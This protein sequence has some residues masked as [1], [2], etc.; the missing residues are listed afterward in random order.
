MELTRRA[1]I[2]PG[3]SIKPPAKLPDFWE[4]FVYLCGAVLVFFWLSWQVFTNALGSPQAVRWS[5]PTSM[6]LKKVSELPTTQSPPITFPNI[7]CNQVSYRLNGESNMRSGCYSDSAYGMFDPDSQLMIFNGSDEALPILPYMAYQ[8]LVPWPGAEFLSLD[9]VNTGGSTLGLYTNPLQA[10]NDKR[11]L[12]FQ[13]TGKQLNRPPQMF[14]TDKTGQKLIINAQTLAFSENGAWM[15]AES[16]SRSIFRMNLASLDFKPFTPSFLSPSGQVNVPSHIAVEDSGQFVALFNSPAKTFRVYDLSSCPIKSTN[17]EPE[18]CPYHDY[19][20]FIKSQVPKVSTIKNL[21][22]VNENLISFE[23]IATDAAQSGIYVISPTEGID[24]LMDYLGLGDSYTSGE[25]AYN[26]RPG[27]D[28]EEN[29]CHLSINSYPML[30]TRD[31]FSQQGGNSVAC[32]GAVMRD[33]GSIEDGYRGQ[34]KGAL[35][36]RHLRSEQPDLLSSV[37]AN[38]APGYIAQ[39]RFISHYQ[40]RIITVSV[41]GNDIGFGGILESCVMPKLSRHFG[42]N[43]CYSTYEDRQEVIKLVD[44]T[45]P[46]WTNLFKDLKDKSPHGHVYAIGYPLIASDQGACA[47]NVNLSRNEIAF[48]IELIKYINS[49]IQKS[50]Q[51]AGISYIDIEDALDGHKLCQTKSYNVAVNGLSAGKDGG[52]FGVKVIGKESYH[53][54]ALGHQLI[55]QAILKKTKNFTILQNSSENGNGNGSSGG[56]S[57]ATP[58]PAQLLAAPKTGRSVNIRVPAKLADAVVKKG[59]VFKISSAD[60]DPVKPLTS[61]KVIIGKVIDPPVAMVT[62]NEGGVIDA[63]ATVP[64]GQEGGSQEL[65]IVGEANSGDTIDLV[66]PIYIPYS[67]NDIDGDGLTNQNDSCPAAIN[68][69]IDEDRDQIDDI[70]DN[71]IGQPPA[72]ADSSAGAGSSTAGNSQNTVSGQGSIS[73]NPSSNTSAVG[74]LTSTQS[75]PNQT[76]NKTVQNT[77]NS[78]KTPSVARN[79]K[80]NTATNSGSIA[81]RPVKTSSNISGSGQSGIAALWQLKPWLWIIMAF[82]WLFLFL[83][84][85]YRDNKDKP[86]YHLAR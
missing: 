53:P 18:N 52:I 62:S 78:I 16:V 86:Q 4:I 1:Q 27:T 5:D 83:L 36:F 15:V 22:F 58:D 74:N 63:L 12:L 45:A 75:T 24:N 70:C 56:G 8:L 76:V 61:Y 68:S 57:I 80:T 60:T 13:L 21:S 66:Q 34:V 51:K 26:Y 73:I 84:I 43:D 2:V 6:T 55:E 40:P 28:N 81:T 49:N 48:S 31:L 7:K 82:M 23:L 69:G 54:N 29:M 79:S 85:L 44:R 65:H 10:M 59:S 41:G 35:D 50:A 72:N 17:L 30:L 42:D 11:N 9:P 3:M 64:A 77:N 38:F 47:L 32:S 14:L 39:Q 20:D 33:I 19:F 46:R 37:M 25:G 67:D 71:H